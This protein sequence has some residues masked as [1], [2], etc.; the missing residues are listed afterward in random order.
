MQAHRAHLNGEPPSVPH[1][2][3]HFVSSSCAATLA[4]AAHIRRVDEGM[5]AHNLPS[6]RF[7][8]LSWLLTLHLNRFLKILARIQ[9]GSNDS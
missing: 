8:Q 2:Q 6:S 9:L 1:L 4:I 5:L 7:P 3:I